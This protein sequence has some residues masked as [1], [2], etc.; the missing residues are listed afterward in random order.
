M[1][2]ILFEKVGLKRLK[3]RQITKPTLHCLPAKK[4]SMMK[5]KIFIGCGVK[6]VKKSGRAPGDADP[7]MA[8]ITDIR[9][10]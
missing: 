8:L 4:L 10:R 1:I 2:M 7:W 3:K 6:K 5:F 9:R